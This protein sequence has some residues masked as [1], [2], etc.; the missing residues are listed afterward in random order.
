MAKQSKEGASP[1][2]ALKIAQAAQ[3]Q[4]AKQLPSQP[5]EHLEVQ[6]S[7]QLGGEIAA[8]PAKALAKSV[9]PAYMK[10]TTYVRKQTHLAVKTRLVSQ[11]KELSDLV[12]ELLSD[13]LQKQS[14]PVS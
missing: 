7:K 14:K 4:P 10:F 2:D 8:S 13:W 12:E 11:D 3:R 5:S 1:F 6:M 9:D